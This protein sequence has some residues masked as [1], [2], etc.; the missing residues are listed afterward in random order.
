MQAGHVID[1]EEGID[2]Q[3]PVGGAPRDTL[4]VEAMARHADRRQVAVER[5][6]VTRDVDRPGVRV[7]HDEDQ[8]VPHGRRQLA[9]MDGG[10]VELGEAFDARDARE[11]AV[12]P[13][14]PAVIGAGERLLAQHLVLLD[15][16][17]ARRDGGR[18]SGRR[19][20]RRRARG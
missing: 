19:G 15:Q 7:E 18:R 4:A 11:R 12:E 9:Q 14:G 1:L 10:A 13:V 3:L 5:A 16:Q 17:S 8:A 2:D 20:P 6:E